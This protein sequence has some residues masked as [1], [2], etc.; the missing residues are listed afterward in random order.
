MPIDNS[1]ME[2]FFGTF[3]NELLYNPLIK[4]HNNIEMIAEI[5]EYFSYYNNDRIQKKLGYLTHAQ[6]R[7]IQLEKSLITCS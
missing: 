3:K 5:E 6:Y 7:I 1:H 2:N 4:V